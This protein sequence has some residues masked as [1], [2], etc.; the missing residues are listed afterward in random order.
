[1]AGFGI[2]NTGFIPKKL[3]DILQSLKMN[4]QTVTD[5]DTGEHL[6]VDF[7][8]NDPFVQMLNSFAQEL[9]TCWDMLGLV[10]SQF[11]PLQATGASLS[12]LVQLNGLTRYAGTPSTVVLT[13]TG[14]DNALVPAGTRC[15]DENNN[16]IWTTVSN[17]YLAQGAGDLVPNGSVTAK[18]TVN[19]P[20]EAAVGT[21][22]KIL[23][24][25]PSVLSVINETAAIP[26]E[27][28][29]SDASLRLR[30][31]RSTMSYSRGMAESIHAAIM[32]LDGVAYCKIY[33][34]RTTSTDSQTGIPAKSIAVIVQGGDDL[35]IAKQI[36]NRA[37]LCTGFYGNT[38]V[39]YQDTMGIGHVVR[40]SR[41]TAIPIDVR[42]TIAQVEG[43]FLETDYAD[44]IK[45]NIVA[46]AR[47]GIA[48]LG[49][50][51][52]KFDTFGFPVGEDVSVSR[53]YTPVNAVKGVKIVSLLIKKASSSASPTT[54]DVTIAWN[55]VA[56]FSPSN[57]TINLNA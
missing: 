38:S 52:D 53:L 37:G 25:L 7:E 31:E 3:S 22:T 48:G 42:I 4:L 28:N 41:P 21:I 57:I 45:A 5:P 8:S 50:S 15:T 1:M 29:E 54:N 13:F 9:A 43:G 36:F 49:I 6:Q 10:Y 33:A 40:F 24:E 11:N 55:E 56:E 34:N 46:F 2:T 18:A 19:G 17:V 51:T 14:G 20:V 35:E 16:V 27:S 23:D 12:G 44:K 39:T 26:G 32:G 30:R 47:N